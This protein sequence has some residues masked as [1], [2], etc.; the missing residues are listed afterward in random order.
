[1]TKSVLVLNEKDGT[2][3]EFDTKCA[4]VMPSV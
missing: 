3:L 2:L 4:R 1:M